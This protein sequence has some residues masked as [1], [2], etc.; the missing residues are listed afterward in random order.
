MT[1]RKTVRIAPEQAA[2]QTVGVGEGAGVGV[3]QPPCEHASQQLAR[4]PAHAVPPGGAL[5]RSA[6]RLIVH[7]VLPA[8]SVEQQETAPGLPQAE[9]RAHACTKRLQ[10]AGSAPLVT[11][12]SRMRA[13]HLR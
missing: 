6:A 13:E 3:E 2:P 12:T 8:T 11:W 4:V 7:A 10:P 5:Q 9:R 1:I